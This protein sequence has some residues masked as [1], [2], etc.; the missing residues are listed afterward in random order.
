MF[1][2][3]TIQ[4]NTDGIN[5]ADV[6]SLLQRTDMTTYDVEL[7]Q[8]A[9]ENS[10]KVIFIY[11]GDILIGCG[12]LLSDFAYQSV[13]YDVAVDI[14]SQGKGIGKMIVRLLTEDEEDKNIILYATPGKEAFYQKFGFKTAKTGMCRFVDME[15][16]LEKGFI[17]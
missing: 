12:R 16:A 8:K 4:K 15:S 9:F 10:A 7:H 17:D 6:K 11:H 13:I 14:D 1:M 5:W 2:D 3:L